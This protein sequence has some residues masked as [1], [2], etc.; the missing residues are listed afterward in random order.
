MLAGPLLFLELLNEIMSVKTLEHDR[1][2]QPTFLA[3]SACSWGHE[4]AVV[5][6]GTE[7]WSIGPRR[8]DYETLR[9]NLS[10][11]TLSVRFGVCLATNM[12]AW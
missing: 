11:Q 3:K 6:T 10:L 9:A 5:V 1:I 4:L 8:A 2:L 12:S 7:R